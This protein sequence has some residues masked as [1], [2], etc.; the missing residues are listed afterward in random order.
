MFYSIAGPVPSSVYQRIKKLEDR[1]LELEGLS[2]EYFQTTVSVSALKQ[3]HEWHLKIISQC[4]IRGHTQVV[5][6]LT[7]TQPQRSY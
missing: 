1:I 7:V 2:P 3:I 6:T 5:L 4:S